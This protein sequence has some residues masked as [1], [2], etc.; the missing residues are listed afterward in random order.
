MES[1][2]RYIDEHVAPKRG[3]GAGVRAAAGRVIGIHPEAAFRSAARGAG[4]SGGG[5]AA[6][7][8]VMNL[9]K[10]PAEP[11]GDYPEW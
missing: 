4:A 8:K 9:W 3:R 7:W 5:P 11:E 1:A 2:A 10:R 6:E